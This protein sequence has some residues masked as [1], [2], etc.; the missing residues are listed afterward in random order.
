MR[1]PRRRK[2]ARPRA[3]HHPDRGLRARAYARSRGGG[4]A[5]ERVCLITRRAAARTSARARP[6]APQVEDVLIEVEERPQAI[7]R[8]PAELELAPCEPVHPH[9]RSR[10]RSRTR[11]RPRTCML[12]STIAHRT[13]PLPLDTSVPSPASVE[14]EPRSAPFEY[15]TDSARPAGPTASRA[16]QE[17]VS[18]DYMIA[19]RRSS[20][21]R[22]VMRRDPIAANPMSTPRRRVLRPR[23]TEGRSGACARPRSSTQA[24]PRVHT[25]L[26]ARSRTAGCPA[27]CR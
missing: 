15:R 27:S 21:A 9:A 14:E 12:T 17:A 20:P 13:T 10:A 8:A 23:C 1:P 26:R 24:R 25:C 19:N 2:I 18:R 22:T 6:G 4:R 11:G 7:A 5:R 3:D 16:R